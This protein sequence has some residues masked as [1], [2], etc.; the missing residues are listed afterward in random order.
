MRHERK[1]PPALATWLLR[2]LYH[3]DTRDALTGDLFERYSEGESDRW[4]W[5]Q[6]LVAVTLDA[7]RGLRAHWPQICFSASGAGLLLL[8]IGKTMR[9]PAIERVWVLGLGLPWPISSAYDFGFRGAV[10]ALIVQPLLAVPLLIDNAF[11]W[12]KIFR[13][14]VISFGLIGATFLAWVL[15]AFPPTPMRRCFAAFLLFAALL[16]SAWAGRRT[17]RA[18]NDGQHRSQRRI[19]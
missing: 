17:L 9:L 18:S 8:V 11:S 6:V 1:P 4:F 12:S 16:I 3:R 10:A 5:R 14:F 19:V 2:R 7:L 13:T 15:F